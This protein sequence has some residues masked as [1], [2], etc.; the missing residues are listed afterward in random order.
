MANILWVLLSA[1]VI[2]I[3][4]ALVGLIGVI[5]RWMDDDSS[6]AVFSVFFNT[7][8]RVWHKAY[9]VAALDIAIIG[10][11]LVN[12]RIFQ[13]MDTSE[14][15]T[16]ISRSVTISVGLG[17]IFVNLYLWTLIAVCD[18]PLRRLLT[19]AVQLT[20]AQPLWTLGIAVG[21]GVVVIVTVF[22]PAALLLVAS[23]A[24]GA[25]ILAW[26]VRRVVTI[27]IPR[28]QF[29]LLDVGPY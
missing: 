10:I 8:R 6:A 14:V 11:V 28:D 2:T 21:I 19:L 12:L 1:L 5:Y 9:L 4:L 20:F 3:P 24:V 25:Y 7:I 15:L 13:F 22:S 27:Y 23:G 16:F 17:L 18:A 29:P 26:G